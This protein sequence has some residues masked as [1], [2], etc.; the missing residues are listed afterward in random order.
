MSGNNSSDVMTE[1]EPIEY[2]VQVFA[3]KFAVA[4]CFVFILPLL[5]TCC[6][7][8]YK[9]PCKGKSKKDRK[10]KRF[11]IVKYNDLYESDIDELKIKT[12]N[13]KKSGKNSGEDSHKK[14]VKD[15]QPSPQKTS[16]FRRI[17]CCGSKGVQRGDGSATSNLLNVENGVGEQ[18]TVPKKYIYYVFDTMDN[19]KFTTLLNA[20]EDSDKVFENFETFVNVIIRTYDPSEVE[21]LLQI[22]SP[23]GIAYKFEY[24]YDNLMRL[25]NKG[26][27]ITALTDTYCA[28]GGYMLACACNKI[29]CAQNANVGSV[30][31]ALQLYNYSKLADKVGIEDIILTTGQYKRPFPVGSPYTQDDKDRMTG[32]VSETFETFKEIVKLGRNLTDEQMAP[33]IEARVYP[34]HIAHQH[35]MVDEICLSSTYVDKISEKHDVYMLVPTEHNSGMFSG[36]VKDIFAS[37]SLSH[38]VKVFK[39]QLVEGIITTQILT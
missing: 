17:F 20:S 27:T 15:G 11:D 39:Q 1:Y 38:M 36:I 16:I 5:L 19:T 35:K 24:T 37:A 7:C 23:G 31:V 9:S 29:I 34:G 10:E 26:F 3:A 18:T 33:V 21:I 12:K 22:E 6:C 25:K 2:I 30:G 13:D 14:S 28:S 8:C 32:M 4:Y